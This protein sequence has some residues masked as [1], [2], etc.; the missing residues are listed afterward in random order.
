MNLILPSNRKRDFLITCSMNIYKVVD[1]RFYILLLSRRQLS[2]WTHY[3]MLHTAGTQW[4]KATV[5][6]AP[7]F[8]VILIPQFQKFWEPLLLSCTTQL[9]I[10]STRANYC[11]LNLPTIIEFLAYHIAQEASRFTACQSWMHLLYCVVTVVECGCRP[12]S[13]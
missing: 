5:P 10:W 7:S 2:N 9:Y 13:M 11:G 1:K 3:N 12:L 6:P 8:Q 4:N